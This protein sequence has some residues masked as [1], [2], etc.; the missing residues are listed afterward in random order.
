MSEPSRQGRPEPKSPPRRRPRR[1]E[2]VAELLKRRILSGVY[3][4]GDKIPAETAL[5]VELLV[6]RF[7]VREAMNKL[8][9]LRLIAR[10]AGVGTVVL[11]YGEH[12]GLEVVE[13]LV[14][15][16]EGV[17]DTKLLSDLLEFARVLGAEIA[18]LAAE[19]RTEDDLLRLEHVLLSLRRETAVSKLL[20]LDFQLHTALADAAHNLVPKLLLNGVRGALEKYAPYLE[21]LWVSPGT[22]MNEYE[23]VVAAVRNRDDSQARALMRGVWTERHTRFVASFQPDPGSSPTWRSPTDPTGSI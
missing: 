20:W 15:S 16:P 21:T 2:E 6:H 9:E 4:P 22:I 11:P 23:H 3:A 18:G 13:Y 12:A 17:V 7:T 10:R 8:E 1:A 14:V 19:R 5:A